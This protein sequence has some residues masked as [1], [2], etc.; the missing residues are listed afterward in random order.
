[1]IFKLFILL[2]LVATGFGYYLHG[3][4]C[5]VEEQEITT[6]LCYMKPT[7][8]CG[9][10]TD[11]GEVVFQAIVPDEPVC[12]DVVD[13]VCIPA[14]VPEEGCK[15]LTHKVCFPSDKVVDRPSGKIPEPYADENVCR[16]LPKA[17]CK[18]KVHKVPKT[19]C[20]PVEAKLL[21]NYY[22]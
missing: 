12:A 10:E 6:S 3:S 15:D 21:L 9:T 13:K 4:N 18:D 8:V 19:V 5:K 17:E 14:K 11:E 22:Y 1:M 2:G 20:E 16:L 7:K